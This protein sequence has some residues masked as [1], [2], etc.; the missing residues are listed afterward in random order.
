MTKVAHLLLFTWE[1]KDIK[2][3]NSPNEFQMLAQRSGSH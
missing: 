1:Q 3:N 2:Y